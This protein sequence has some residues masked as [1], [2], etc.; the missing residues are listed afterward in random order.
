MLGFVCFIPLF[1][2]V[3]A[4]AHSM[5]TLPASPYR[6]SRQDSRAPR[7]DVQYLAPPSPPVA[8]LGLPTLPSNAPSPRWIARLH[9]RAPAAFTRCEW[10][11][12]AK[13]WLAGRE[14]CLWRRES[15]VATEPHRHERWTD[16][17][18]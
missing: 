11:C 4:P 3:V 6:L 5:L 2:G 13:A 8:G 18:L 16:A 9:S 10:G 7:G 1:G 15:R 12:R 14:A 17:S